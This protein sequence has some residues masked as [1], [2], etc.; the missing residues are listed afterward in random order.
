MV[1]SLHTICKVEQIIDESPTVRTLLFSNDVLQNCKPG[2]FSMVWIPGVAELPMS[3]MIRPDDK[4]GFAFTI[5][6]RGVSSTALYGIQIGSKIGVRGPFGNSFDLKNGNLLL[7]GGGTGLVPLLRLAKSTTTNDHVT[8]II[9]SKSK[10][11]VLFE[12]FANKLLENQPHDVIVT[13]EDNDY[14]HKGFPTDVMTQLYNDDKEFDAVYTCGPELL[15]SKVVDESNSR[16]FFVQASIERMMKC[17]I[18][19]C[20][21]CCFGNLISCRDGTVFD[22]PTLASNPEFG[23][24]YRNKSGSLEQY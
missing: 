7:I 6:K 13:T 21:S 15:M 23:K 18:G 24:S 22:G 19:M 5:R 16:G 14:G 3:I 8:L 20:G 11:E 9:G 4:P 1:T 2:Q 12:N 17:G 10:D